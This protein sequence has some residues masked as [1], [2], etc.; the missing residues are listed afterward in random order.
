MISLF[1]F[2]PIPPLVNESSISRY[3]KFS[4]GVIS[5]SQCHAISKSRTFWNWSR[6]FCPVPSEKETLV[7]VRWNGLIIEGLY[8]T[9]EKSSTK[10]GWKWFY[11]GLCLYSITLYTMRK[12]LVLGNEHSVLKFALILYNLIFFSVDWIWANIIKR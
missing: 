3:L 11:R 10:E 8:F 6:T 1:F 12:Y 5:L 2:G 9:R 4:A 7:P